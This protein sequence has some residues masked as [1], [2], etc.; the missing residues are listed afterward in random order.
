VFTER[1]CGLSVRHWTAHDEV[2]FAMDQNTHHG[3]LAAIPERRR[4]SLLPEQVA[5]S[6]L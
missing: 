5:D 2:V 1:E 4:I 3:D 6:S